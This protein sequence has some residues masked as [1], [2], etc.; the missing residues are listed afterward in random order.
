MADQLHDHLGRHG[1]AP[2]VD[3]FHVGPGEEVQRRIEETLEDFAFLLLLESPL[4]SESDWVFLEVDYALSH[5]M[6]L[7]ILHWPAEA[8][9]VPGTQGLPRQQLN[10]TDLASDGRFQILTPDAL[11]AVLTEVEAAHARALRRRRRNLLVS[12]LEAARARGREAVEQPGGRVLVASGAG[13]SL[14]SVT[15]RL[16]R[17]DDLFLLDTACQEMRPGHSAGIEGV[18]VHAARQLPSE[19]TQVLAWS[20]GDRTL[21]LVPENAIGAYW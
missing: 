3:R 14:V 20:I 10:P 18:V 16:P 2:F 9:L 15:P 1:F 13:E 21:Y 11:E 6:G 17:V 5:S 12:V 4:A 8:A 7:H 19:L